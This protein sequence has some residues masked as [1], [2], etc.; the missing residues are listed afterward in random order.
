MIEIPTSSQ[1]EVLQDRYNR[2]VIEELER[3]REVNITLVAKLE[4]IKAIPSDITDV[5]GIITY[6]QGI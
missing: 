3:L 4:Y 1:D 2:Q 6:L 5:Q